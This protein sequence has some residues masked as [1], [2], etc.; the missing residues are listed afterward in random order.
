LPGIHTAV[1]ILVKWL[2][3]NPPRQVDS[4]FVPQ[5]FAS[6]DDRHQQDKLK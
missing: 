3:E 1:I 2:I 6:S 4:T 5:T